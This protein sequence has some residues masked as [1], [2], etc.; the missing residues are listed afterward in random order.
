MTKRKSKITIV[1]IADNDPITEVKE[2]VEEATEEEVKEPVEE[3]KEEEVK[4]DVKEEVKPI[5]NVKE[6][7]KPIEEVKEEVKTELKE[8][9]KSTTRVQKLY[10]CEK[11]HKM[12]TASSLKYYHHKN[13]TQYEQP[14]RRKYNKKI[15]T[16]ITETITP[17]I[18]QPITETITPI[19]ETITPITETITPITE[20]ITP[21]TETITPIT[22]TI[23]IIKPITKT[24]IQQTR[25]KHTRIDH[26]IGVMNQMSKK[27]NKLADLLKRTYK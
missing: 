18:T 26:T 9:V 27:K 8:E 5:E 23:K 6:E 14:S 16:P 20:T 19:T 7:V 17:I 10:E 2:P 22:E 21:I 25:V 15:I 1:D 12:L 4:E 13:C 3:A 24:N 11:C